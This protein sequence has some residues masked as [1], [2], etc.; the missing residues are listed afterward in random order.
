MTK[1]QW[2]SRMRVVKAAIA[3]YILLFIRLLLWPNE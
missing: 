1:D 3:A 2:H